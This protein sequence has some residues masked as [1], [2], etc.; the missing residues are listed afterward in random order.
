MISYKSFLLAL[1]GVLLSFASRG[2]IGSFFI[3]CLLFGFKGSFLLLQDFLVLL[4]SLGVHLDGGVAEPAV[5]TVPMLGHEG[6]GSTGGAGLALLGH[7]T[8]A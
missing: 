8:L 1:F 5:V 4:D 2:L 7:G 3:L 6:S